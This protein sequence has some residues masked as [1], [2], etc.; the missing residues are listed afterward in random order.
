M[1]NT[2]DTDPLFANSQTYQPVYFPEGMAI[3]IL[4]NTDKPYLPWTF[5]LPFRGPKKKSDEPRT[6][7]N[8]LRQLT[9]ATFG[10][11]AT[12][13]EDNF[14]AFFRPHPQV[15]FEV[16]PKPSLTLEFDHRKQGKSQHL[17][18]LGVS[19]EY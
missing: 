16:S 1:V 8:G 13:V 12:K 2:E 7:A 14:T 6:H 10:I 17:E 18:A 9:Q 15:A 3:N 4:P 5:R 11:P 19:I